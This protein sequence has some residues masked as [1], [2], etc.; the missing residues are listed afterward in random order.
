MPQSMQKLLNRLSIR[1]LV[2]FQAVYQQQSYSKAADL[3]GLSQPAVSSQVRQLESA[4]GFKLFEFIGRKLYCTD[5][6]ERVAQS[7][8]R[9]FDEFRSLH[10]DA[11]SLAGQVSGDL[12]LAVVSSAQYVVPW[13]A[14][15]FSERYPNTN[16]IIQVMN[17]AQAIER[18]KANVDDL[19]IMALVPTDRSLASIPFLD[20]DLVPIVPA[21]HSLLT[22]PTPIDPQWFLDNKLIVREAGSGSRLALEQHCQ[23]KRLR[24]APAQELGS[25]EL[26]KHAVLAG[27]GVAVVPRSAVQAEL[28]LGL[29]RMPNLKDFPLRRSWCLVY[30]V[31]KNL[32]PVTRLF[33]KYVQSNLASIHQHFK[34]ESR[35]V[36]GS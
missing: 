14:K 1:Q 6:G 19:T 21:G 34:P 31:A 27:S 22:L 20:N 28:K 13:L 30:P 26:I 2:V 35:G 17:R 16:V 11:H 5:I 9:I 18:L 8:T 10:N 32:S 33:V 36:V 7:V 29:L 15:Q 25:T 12:R 3:L 24:M 23:Q 4:L